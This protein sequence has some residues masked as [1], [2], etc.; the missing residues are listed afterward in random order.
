M[1]GFVKV[2]KK[3]QI[4]C[5]SFGQN[6]HFKSQEEALEAAI[7]YVQGRKDKSDLTIETVEI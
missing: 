6:D 4:A 1:K 7:N 5:F 3:K 2:K